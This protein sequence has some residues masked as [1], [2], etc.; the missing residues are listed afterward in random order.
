MFFKKKV[1]IENVNPLVER[2]VE[3]DEN[4]F[5]TN[6]ELPNG[7]KI[8][9][10]NA[11]TSEIFIRE[12]FQYKYIKK[13]LENYFN[14]NFKN[15]T[16]IDLGCLE[17]QWTLEFAKL[18]FNSTGLEVRENNYQNCLKILEMSGLN[19]L[20]FIKEDV[21]NLDK[22]QSF[23]VF[24]CNGIL[25]HL[26]RPA[27]LL[28]TIFELT[29]EIAII[30][31]HFSEDID[32]NSTSNHYLSDL[33]TNENLKGRWY[34]E[35]DDGTDLK[36]KEK[37]KWRAY[38]NN[39]SFWIEKNCLVSYLYE[40]GFKHVIEVFDSLNVSTSLEYKKQLRTFLIAYKK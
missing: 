23:D 21:M 14:Y 7:E 34:F 13:F 35:Y 37:N 10:S 24:F 31:T 36:D 18:G 27:K 38:Q 1:L 30:D 33:E 12:T 4:S 17:G 20:K 22:Q 5:T 8:L 2:D 32:L 25:Y 11:G 9:R 28:R 19:N 26:D 29:K 3:D 15:K 40:L 6:I 39:K 16:L